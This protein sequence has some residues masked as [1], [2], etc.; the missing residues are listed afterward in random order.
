MTPLAIRH[1]DQSI[2]GLN[3]MTIVPAKNIVFDNTP[4]K[5]YPFGPRWLIILSRSPVTALIVM[6]VNLKILSM[7]F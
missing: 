6:R 7:H 5:K 2:Y 1:T 3:L 4:Y